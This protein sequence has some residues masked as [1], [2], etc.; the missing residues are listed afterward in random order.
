[1]KRRVLPSL[2]VP[3]YPAFVLLIL[4][5]RPGFGAQGL[6]LP[7]NGENSQASVTQ[8]VGPVRVTIDY[9]SPRVVR[10]QTDRRGKIWGE[11]VPWG[12]TDLGFNGCKE[13]PWRGGANENTTFAVTHLV[14]V[15]GDRKST[16]LNSS[17]RLTSR[18]PSSA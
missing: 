11:L 9:S 18:M 16:R 5:A 14:K 6:T 10:G 17:H 7:P 4:L 3:I 8:A 12:L 1:M 13:C 2:V 15:Q